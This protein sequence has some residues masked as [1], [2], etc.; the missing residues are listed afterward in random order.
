[1]Y[2]GMDQSS[3]DFSGCLE[4]FR[5]KKKLTADNLWYCPSCKDHVEAT[6]QM[7][8]YTVPPILIF[9][10]QRF[11]AHNQYFS[12]KKDDLIKFPIKGLDMAPYVA[13]ESQKQEG[14]LIYDLYAVSNH[15][16][17]MNFGHYTAN[18]KNPKTGLWYDY[19]DSH[20]TEC[21]DESEVVT[22]E[23]YNLFYQ[24]RNFYPDGNVDFEKIK[25]TPDPSNISTEET[26]HNNS[27]SDT[28]PMKLDGSGQKAQSV[29]QPIQSF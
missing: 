20:V 26:S 21:Q 15:S 23:A 24:R 16:G 3:Q 4:T 14:P 1:M 11:K 9:V 18:C 28:S 2:G 22:R 5:K 13:C 12:S 8:F 19:N 7:E 29:S 27:N 17:S 6:K 25:V 10:L